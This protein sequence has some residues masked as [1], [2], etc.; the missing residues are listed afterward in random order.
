MGFGLLILQWKQQDHMVATHHVLLA[1]FCFHFF[2][3]IFWVVS[4]VK[5]QK[6]A[7]NDKNSVC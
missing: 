2:I 4:V 1:F 7:L 6:M 5:G 3:L